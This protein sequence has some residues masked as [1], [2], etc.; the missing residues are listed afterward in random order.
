MSAGAASR[1]T[2]DRGDE[3]DLMPA[4]LVRA[5]DAAG[6]LIDERLINLAGEDARQL[7]RAYEAAL[8]VNFTPSEVAMLRRLLLRVEASARR[9]SGR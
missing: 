5:A 8:L 1:V 4:L 7:A 9:L 6:G 2:E 3:S